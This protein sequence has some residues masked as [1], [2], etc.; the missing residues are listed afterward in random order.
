MRYTHTTAVTTTHDTTMTMTMTMVVTLTLDKAANRHDAQQ[1]EVEH[2]EEALERG[3]R[4]RESY[5]DVPAHCGHDLVV[6]P[7]DLETSYI[8]HSAVNSIRQR[9]CASKT[10]EDESHH[11]RHRD[12]QEQDTDDQR[13]LITLAA[14]ALFVLHVRP[15][16]LLPFALPAQWSHRRGSAEIDC[17]RVDRGLAFIARVIVMF[18]AAAVSLVI[19]RV[20]ERDT[21]I[22]R[23]FDELPDSINHPWQL[24]Q[25]STIVSRF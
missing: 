20:P 1:R 5:L 6:D 24:Y 2:R 25:L 8:E 13:R 17:T 14:E 4:F 3:K 16:R 10:P 19:A 7:Y 12:K 21:M 9:T 11:T 18:A 23:S 15:R 22:F